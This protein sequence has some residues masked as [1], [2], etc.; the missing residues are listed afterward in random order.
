VAQVASLIFGSKVEP[1]RVIGE[2]LKRTTSEPDTSEAFLA[3]LNNHVES[4]AEPPA[5]HDGFVTH[6]LSSWIESCFGTIRDADSSRLVRVKP[7]PIAGPDGAAKQLS[8][9][10]GVDE[11]LC[12][13]AI[14]AQLL[15]GVRVLHAQTGMPVFAFRLHQ[16]ISRGDAAYASLESETVRHITVHPQQY[17]PGNRDRRLFPLVFCRECGQEYYSVSIAGGDADQQAVARPPGDR[18]DTDGRAGYI[19][20]SLGSPWPVDALQQGRYPE[21]WLEQDGIRLKSSARQLVPRRIEVH[22]DGRIAAGGTVA[23]FVPA[24]FRLCLNCGVSY[25]GHMRS[26]FAKLGTLGSEGRSTATTILSL[27]TVRHLRAEQTLAPEARKLLSFTDN[28]QDASL[29]AGHF[30]DFVQVG[31]LR[32][33]LYRAIAAAGPAGLA[34][35]PRR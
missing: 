32:S 16:F 3:A 21:D 7:R 26:D 35:S 15:A 18:S 1:A 8:E 6:P 19:H 29:Q 17:V 20:L 5:D 13:A 33:G 22:P 31:L 4:A 10:I 23:H 14:Q 27:S 24:P 30:N 34:H 11:K 12:V 28:R 9:Q 25:R 2:T